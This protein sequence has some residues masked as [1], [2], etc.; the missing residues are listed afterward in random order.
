MAILFDIEELEERGPYR[1]GV[2]LT[3]CLRE[4]ILSVAK[5]AKSLT[6]LS[7]LMGTTR[8]WLYRSSRD[9]GI[10]EQ[11]RDLCARAYTRQPKDE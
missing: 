2:V 6:E 4:H 5:R 8:T 9:L 3:A 7:R 11:V 10:L 1:P